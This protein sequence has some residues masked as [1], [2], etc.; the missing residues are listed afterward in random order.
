MIA[1]LV[2]AYNLVPSLPTVD[3]RQ[4]QLAAGQ[5]IVGV[6][7][8]STNTVYFSSSANYGG[9]FS[10]PVKVADAPNLSLG[11]HRGPRIAITPTAIV[12]SAII[13]EKGGGKDG[14][15]VA[16]RSTD[17]GRTWSQPVVINDVP[18]AA[19]EG[20][21][22]MAAGGK[23][24]LFATWL[25]L[26]SKGTKLYGAS[27]T[28]GGATW[29][30]N[31]LAYESPDGHIC[32]C[33]HPSVTI[34]RSGGVHVMWRNWLNGSRDLYLAEST[35]GGRTFGEAQKLG[36]GTWRLNAC[37]M[38]GG[39]LALDNSGKVVSAWRRGNEVFVAPAGGIETSLGIGKDAAMAVG[40]DGVYAGW[41]NSNGVYVR[42]PGRPEPVRLDAEGG[43]L[44]L[45]AA[46]SGPVIAAW[47]KKG[48]IE[49]RALP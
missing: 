40:R 19:R 5:G 3:Y 26:R 28:D 31:V 15:L 46:P 47:Q 4:P 2:L 35:D 45:V 23:G 24:L 34:D 14:D 13:G 10:P 21:H 11:S 1:L 39:S 44:N 8:G 7:F 27:S 9:T 41:T 43:F 38:D 20:L 32:E 16:W 18:G 30:K 6:T 29:S 42:V 12:I 25:D 36:G 17:R 37:P 48:S 22:A 49:F 33:C